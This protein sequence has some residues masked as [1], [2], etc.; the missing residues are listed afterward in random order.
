M[1]GRLAADGY[2]RPE[3]IPLLAITKKAAIIANFNGHSDL[4]CR[5]PKLTPLT[6]A[7]YLLSPSVRNLTV[8]KPSKVPCALHAPFLTHNLLHTFFT[9][10]LSYASLISAILEPPRIPPLAPPSTYS[11]RMGITVLPDF[12]HSAHSACELR[13][14]RFLKLWLTTSTAISTC[15][16]LLFLSTNT[17]V[18]I[19]LH[20][21]HKRDH[22]FTV[23]PCLPPS[24]CP[25]E[26]GGASGIASTVTTVVPSP[27]SLPR[28]ALASPVSFSTPV[29]P[30]SYTPSFSRC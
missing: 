9:T 15:H 17:F 26:S 16:R 12:F 19:L 27:S 3:A 5:R 30:A 11:T 8:S 6:V 29:P 13:L 25:V 20:L 10:Y 24:K 18:K 21:V 22:A 4:P 14:P 23:F 7:F 1:P 28:T 2:I